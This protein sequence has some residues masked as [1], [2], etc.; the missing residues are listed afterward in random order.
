M[1]G[2]VQRKGLQG[3]RADRDA[4]RQGFHLKLVK[5]T[6]KVQIEHLKCIKRAFLT[7]ISNQVNEKNQFLRFQATRII[8]KAKI[9][10]TI[11]IAPDI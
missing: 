3:V 7:L 1:R 11:E 4:W 10:F 2:A 6:L 5:G 9:G 8:D